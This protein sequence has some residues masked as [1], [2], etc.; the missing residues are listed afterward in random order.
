MANFRGSHGIADE[1]Q[2]ERMSSFHVD[3]LGSEQLLN[4]YYFVGFEKGF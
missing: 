3:M 4:T 2:F 1:A